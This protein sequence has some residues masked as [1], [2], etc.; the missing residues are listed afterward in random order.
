MNTFKTIVQK[1]KELPVLQFPMKKYIRGSQ[2]DVVE[3]VVEENFWPNVRKFIITEDPIARIMKVIC[4]VCWDELDVTCITFPNDKLEVGLVAP[5]GHIMCRACWPRE[6]F[7][8]LHTI[9]EGCQIKVETMKSLR[10]AWRKPETTDQLNPT[11]NMVTALETT[12]NDF[13]DGV[14]IWHSPEDA[15]LDI[16]FIHG[17]SGNRDK[18]WTAPGQ[19]NPWPAELLPSRLSKA[20]LLTYGYDAYVLKKSVSSTNRLV[21]HANNLLHDL[22]AERASSGIVNRPLIFVVHSF[23]GIVCKT[24]LIVSRQNPESHLGQISN[25][26]R[27]IVF[28]GTPHRGSWAAD[29]AKIPAWALGQVKSTNRNILDVLQI[30]NQYLEFIQTSF[31]SMLRDLDKKGRPLQISCFFEELPMPGIGT[32]VS[33]ESASLEGY[34]VFSIHANHSDMAKFGSAEESGFKRLLGE[35]VRWDAMLGTGDSTIS[36]VA[37]L[38]SNG[39][40]PNATSSLQTTT[41]HIFNASGGTQHN[42]TGAGNQFFGNFDGPVYFEDQSRERRKAQVLKRLATS[43]Y[44][45]RKDR[46]PSAVQGTCEWFISHHLYHEWLGQEASKILWVSA[47]P[48][49]GKSVLVKHLVDSVIQTTA[50][51]KVCYFFFKDD[52]ADQKSL[53]SA[54]SSIL[55]QLFMLDTALLSDEILLQFDANGQWLAVSFVELWQILIKVADSNHD[56]EIIC[57]IDAVDEC[58]EQE[59][60][61]LFRALCELCGSK[62]TRNL[63][64]LITSRPYREIGMGFKPLE[65]LNLPVIHLSGESDS[66]M[67]KIV[68]EIDIA[69]RERVKAI[70]VQQSLTDDEQLILITRLLSVRNRTYLWA[71]LTLDLIERQLDISKEKIINITSH[72]PQN[73]NEAYERIMCRTFSKDK[74]TRMLHLII[75]ADRPLTVGEMIVALELQRHH[76]SIDDIE[77]EPE[78]RFRE[79]IRDICGLVTVS[80]SR[81]F[82]LHQTVKEFLISIDH[83]EPTRLSWKYSISE[84]DPNLTLTYLNRKDKTYQRSALSWAAGN[85][86]D[87]VVG[88]L[89]RGLSIGPRSW[90][91]ILRNGANINQFDSDNRTPITYAIWNGHISVVRRLVVAGAWVD[92]P[93]VLGATPTSYAVRNKDF[94]IKI[95]VVR[96]NVP[97]NANHREGEKL[98]LSAAKYGHI[99]VVRVLLE[100]KETNV[101]LKDDEGWTPLMWAINYRHNGIV[102][103]LLAHGADVDIRDRAG[104]SPF[105]FATRYGQFEVAKLIMQTGRADVNRPDLDGLTPLHQAARWKQDDI[106]QLIL[107]TGVAKVNARVG[108]QDPAYSWVIRYSSCSTL[109]LMFD[110]YDDK[111]CIQ[112]CT[113]TI[114]A[115]DKEWADKDWVDKLKIVLRSRKIDVNLGDDKGETILH[116]AVKKRSY[117]IIKE[118]LATENAPTNSRDSRGL[119]P[120]AL[121]CLTLD[122]DAISSFSAADSVDPNIADTNGYTPLHHAV[123]E[124]SV[125]ITSALIATAK[126]KVDMKNRDGRTPLSLACLKGDTALAKCFLHNCQVDINTQDR[127][128]RTPAHNCVWVEDVNMLRLILQTDQVNLNAVDKQRCTPLLLAVRHSKWN[129]AFPL[130]DYEQ[131]VNMKDQNGKTALV[132]AIIHG[133]SGIVRQLISLKQTDLNVRDEEGLTPLSHAAQQGNEEIVRI[134]LEK[135]GIDVDAKDNNG[136]TALVHAAKKGH[137]GVVDLLLEGGKA[138]T[139]IRD[140]SGMTPMALASA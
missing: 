7:D 13:P 54:L 34:S 122:S 57:L 117:R 95:L 28:L 39:K 80:E 68:K 37:E 108:W 75:A 60:R 69:I 106:T 78:D 55:Q 62:K 66:E 27:G 85:G 123:Q 24:A 120:L 114:L 21:D 59:R 100:A 51:R 2:S 115:T 4:S 22:A 25:Y 129:M 102:K 76:Q 89:I 105:D 19:P 81:I 125:P 90:K 3:I 121:A 70:A 40:T 12:R 140:E 32:I 82:L 73:V 83:A 131:A 17:L 43:P 97:S 65:N 61:Q 118:L 107:K 31:L 50:S 111:L 49:C 126:V 23:G 36:P 47:D 130:L 113:Q 58:N 139:W 11:S 52:F 8:S 46:N 38:E 79:K 109:K 15:G 94:G 136:M 137:L 87:G 96:E 64:F 132:W 112:D 84:Q 48:G 44:R 29:W 74:A 72:L 71:H 92:V 41:G 128:G 91:I 133:Q 77:I 14:K 33:K 1:L 101:N 6:T 5:C 124:H 42:N 88:R 93:D 18:T 20:R 135:L 86:H 56:T 104:M 67:T 98:L 138:N 10:Q 103:L 35:L 134:L 30:N 119:T 16:C 9:Y 99:H 110:L 63:K 116:K 53:L 26:T 45:G 127:Y